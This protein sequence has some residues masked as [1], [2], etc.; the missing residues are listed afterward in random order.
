VEACP[1]QA[2]FLLAGKAVIRPELCSAC[3]DC[4]KVCASGAIASVEPPA[5]IRPAAVPAPTTASLA[6]NTSRAKGKIVLGMGL[7]VTVIE[8]HIL[9]R[10][11]DA[12]IAALERRLSRPR[13]VPASS[14]G[15]DVVQ[16]HGGRGLMRRQ[17]R[18]GDPRK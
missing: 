2:I 4:V 11:A 13:P 3:G 8:Q 10:L 9:P 1:P 17:R 18:R 14:T 16:G 15:K 7:A 12:F 6:R 5:L